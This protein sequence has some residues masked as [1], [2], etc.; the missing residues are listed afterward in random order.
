MN[1]EPETLNPKPGTLNLKIVFATHNNNKLVELQQLLK[2]KVTL[3]SLNDLGI[4]TEIEETGET[5]EE[6][7]LL[8]AK[9]VF[10]R[11]GL[12]VF[13]DDTGL[14]IDALNGAPGVIS[15]RFAGEEKSSKKNIEKV[16]NL[17]QGEKNRKARFK[18]IISLIMNGKNH[19]FEGTVEGEILE[20]PIGK[21]GFG[22][23]PIFKPE[24]YDISFAQMELDTK[25]T[26]S[27]RGKAVQKLITF[28]IS[29]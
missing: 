12:D 2:E 19:F 16:L 5:L 1:I 4:L 9:Y 20:Y 10:D 23:D 3:L 24:G 7:A 18:T 11:F 27:H 6:N 22:Y 8:K 25:N 13:A 26:I 15:A 21:E 17:L 29:K 28:L 14:E